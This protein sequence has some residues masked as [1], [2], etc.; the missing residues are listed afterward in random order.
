MYTIQV[1][2]QSAAVYQDIHHLGHAESVAE[3]VERIVSVILLNPQQE[4]LEGRGV[5]IELLHQP[6]LVVH[7]LKEGEHLV[8][9][10]LPHVELGRLERLLALAGQRVLVVGRDVPLLGQQRLPRRARAVEVLR[11]RHTRP[12]SGHDY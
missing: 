12:Q 5:D 1:Y 9:L 2:L 8:G 6:Q 7:L 4:P 3:V 10:P 11:Q